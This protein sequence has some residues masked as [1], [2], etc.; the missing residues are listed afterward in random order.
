MIQFRIIQKS[1]LESLLYYYQVPK[2][3]FLKV[4]YAKNAFQIVSQVIQIFAD[5][6]F[7]S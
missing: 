2:V 7:A 1:K 5:F 3:Q 4:N 6:D